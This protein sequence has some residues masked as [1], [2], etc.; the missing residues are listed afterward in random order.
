VS[1]AKDRTTFLIRSIKSFAVVKK[2]I[3]SKFKKKKILKKNQQTCSTYGRKVTFLLSK[4]VWVSGF[5]WISVYIYIYIPNEK[6]K[7]IVCVCSKEVTFSISKAEIEFCLGERET[8][9]LKKKKKKTFGA[10][11]RLVLTVSQANDIPFILYTYYMI[12]YKK[13]WRHF[14]SRLSQHTNTT[15][16]YP[17]QSDFQNPTYIDVDDDWLVYTSVERNIYLDNAVRSDHPP[18]VRPIFKFVLWLDT[19][20]AVTSQFVPIIKCRKKKRWWTG[21]YYLSC[22]RCRSDLF[23]TQ[24]KSKWTA[25]GHFIFV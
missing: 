24:F 18:C 1:I 9:R 13:S 22:K 11:V 12:I 23:L 10:L 14:D 7:G 19:I 2:K 15:A 5:D 17:I 6:K 21:R 8:A 25:R 4:C 3:N 16:R 20:K